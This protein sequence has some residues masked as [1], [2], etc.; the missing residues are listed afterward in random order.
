MNLQSA[1]GNPQFA[2]RNLALLGFLCCL[3]GCGDQ[4]RPVRQ[5]YNE[6]FP[7]LAEINDNLLK[8]VDEESAK[9]FVDAQ[10]KK[11]EERLK[12]YE[13]RARKFV[14]EAKND[15]KTIKTTQSELDRWE[16][17]LSMGKREIDSFLTVRRDNQARLERLQEALQKMGKDTAN[18]KKV[19]GDIP[20]FGG[21]KEADLDYGF[22]EL[23]W[24]SG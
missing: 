3:A 24:V 13:D 21:A 18:L 23:K 16:R 8:I 15:M 22:K 5:M 11:W 2:I 12:A 19:I 17:A 4:L 7:I 14:Q 9:E 20:K 6:K 10:Q 1:I